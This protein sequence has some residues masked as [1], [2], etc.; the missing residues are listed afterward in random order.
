M[1]EIQPW[2]SQTADLSVAELL[3]DSELPAGVVMAEPETNYATSVAGEFV[4]LNPLALQRYAE[5]QILDYGQK[6]ERPLITKG[7]SHG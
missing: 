5:R 7:G 6:G 2:P 3:G 4:G 1:S